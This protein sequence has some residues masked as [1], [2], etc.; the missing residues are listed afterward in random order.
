MYDKYL[1]KDCIC[2]QTSNEDGYCDGSHSNVCEDQKLD[3]NED[4]PFGD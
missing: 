1:P 4:V 2:G 3:L